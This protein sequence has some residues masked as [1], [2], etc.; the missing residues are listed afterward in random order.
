MNNATKCRI[1][2]FGSRIS[3]LLGL[4]MRP[5]TPSRDIHD[6]INRL[7]PYDLGVPLKRIG[8]PRDGCYLIPDDL[9]GIEHCFSP[10]VGNTAVFENGLYELGIRSFLTDYSVNQAPA[11][12]PDCD[13]EKKFV[14]A[15]NS[16]NVITLDRWVNEKCPVKGSEKGSADLI[17]Q[18][19]IEGAE[20]ETLL[21]ASPETLSRFR[22]IVLEIHKLNHLDNRLFFKFVN[23]T[24]CKLLEQFEIAHLHPNNGAGLTTMA[25]V[26]IPRVAEITLLR[27]D[28]V[29]KK[30]PVEQLPNPLDV[31]NV[32]EQKDVVLPEYWWKPKTKRRAA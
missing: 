5:Q 10:G 11:T 4:Y 32:P 1:K 14:G 21:A 15:A 29:I 26:E 28:R 20:Y 6:L 3:S 19:D 18:M 2:R 22:I 17:L 25:G 13:F 23:A 7:V 9:D 30:S 31:P 8:D 12:L 24:L 16:E 27:K